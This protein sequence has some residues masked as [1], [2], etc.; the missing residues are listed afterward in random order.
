MIEDGLLGA[1]Q[2]DAHEIMRFSDVIGSKRY[3][4]MFGGGG[5]A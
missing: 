1:V 5:S 3:W 4:I 2:W